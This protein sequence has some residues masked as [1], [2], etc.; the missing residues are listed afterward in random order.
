M[1]N[2]LEKLFI[3]T[4][5]LGEMIKGATVIVDTN[6]LLSSYQTKPVTF[7]TMLNILQELVDKERLRI[8]S[9][10]VR[11]FQE[12]RPNRIK[13]I[14]NELQQ[15]INTIDGIKNTQP[16][17]KLNKI[18]PAI[19]VLEDSHT[20]KLIELQQE[21][22]AQINILKEKGN[23]FKDELSVLVLKLSDYMD[24]DPILL[25]YENIIKESY[26]DSPMLFNENELEKE[27]ERRFEQNIPP[28]FRD[29]TKTIN[30]YGDLI[31][32]LQICEL[33]ED[34][35]FITFDNKEDWVYKDSKGNVLGA[36]R[37]LVQ[38]Y[39]EKSGGK[40]IKILHP[41]KFVE[42][43][44]QGHVNSEVTEELNEYKYMT[45]IFKDGL[46]LQEQDDLGME[47][48]LNKNGQLDVFDYIEQTEAKEV[49]HLKR[50][51]K[52]LEKTCEH[53]INMIG[54]V[55]NYEDEH[56]TIL[57]FHLLRNSIFI[58][59]ASKEELEIYNKELK[60]TVKQLQEIFWSPKTLN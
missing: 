41:A 48:S 34:I 46:L 56:L 12:N 14:A 11:E 53:Y 23:A 3:K 4:K 15:F 60:L 36:R 49:L 22:N 29:K 54:D 57:N 39:Y 19:D 25:K 51:I 10:V 24:N 13:E 6:V 59:T 58:D 47:H 32:W 38:E 8:P 7:D 55:E 43:Y 5:P 52:Q 16:P 28:G 44:T 27:G 20:E 45:S 37:E 30:K 50:K 26:F 18:L 21:F 9:H 33:K 1:Q 17:K 40:T 35:V 42:L 2:E 31:L